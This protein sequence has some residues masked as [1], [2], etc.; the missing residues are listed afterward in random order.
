MNVETKSKC[1]KVINRD[2]I[3]NAIFGGNFHRLLLVKFKRLMLI[4]KLTPFKF[5]IFKLPTFV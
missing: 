4:S 3:Q 1:E 2:I 5:G